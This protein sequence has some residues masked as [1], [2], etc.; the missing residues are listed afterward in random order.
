MKLDADENISKSEPDAI[1]FLSAS[2][3]SKASSAYSNTENYCFDK[4]RNR[5]LSRMF[6]ETPYASRRDY[7]G[8]AVSSWRPERHSLWGDAYRSSE[9]A[10]A[11]LHAGPD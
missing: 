4:Q 8:L 10:R 2:S 3:M 9:R 1:Y 11:K 6:Q 7:P 5:T